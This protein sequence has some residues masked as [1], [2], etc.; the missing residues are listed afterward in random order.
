MFWA[1]SVHRRFFFLFFSSVYSLI[2]Q[3]DDCVTIFDPVF[4]SGDSSYLRDHAGYIV[5]SVRIRRYR[6]YIERSMIP[7]PKL[8]AVPGRAKRLL[9]RAAHGGLHA[10]L[11][12][13]AVREGCERQLVCGEDEEHADGRQQP[14]RLC[15]QVSAFLF[16]SPL[17]GVV[18]AVNSHRTAFLPTSSQP[19]ILPWPSSVLSIS[20][21]LHFC[22]LY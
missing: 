16:G 14:L 17:W 6:V 18:D 12:L 2:E 22:S 20:T 13:E 3:A 15:G 19:V 21:F 7:P 10:P 1:W 8:N 9:D 4:T 11:R 5:P